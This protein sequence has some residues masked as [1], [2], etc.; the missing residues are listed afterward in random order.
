M[1]NKGKMFCYSVSGGEEFGKTYP[2]APTDEEIQGFPGMTMCKQSCPTSAA[3]IS[4]LGSLPC[5]KLSW[6]TRDDDLH[7]AHV[8]NEAARLVLRHGDIHLERSRHRLHQWRGQN[9]DP[10]HTYP[11]AHRTSTLKRD[12]DFG[13]SWW[14]CV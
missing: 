9:E 12:G 13:H 5:K 3:Q 2:A 11:G 7:R 8:G 10:R 4:N 6:G 1:G 14:L